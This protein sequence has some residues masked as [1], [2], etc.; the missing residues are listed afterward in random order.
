MSALRR[1]MCALSLPLFLSLSPSALCLVLPAIGLRTRACPVG[2]GRDTRRRPK[3]RS[4]A[5]KNSHHHHQQ[6]HPLNHR[7]YSICT[8]TAIPTATQCNQFYPPTANRKPRPE[9]TCASAA[10]GACVRARAGCCWWWLVGT[11]PGQSEAPPFDKDHDT[12]LARLLGLNL[13]RAAVLPGPIP[14]SPLRQS[15]TNTTPRTNDRDIHPSTRIPHTED[16][17]TSCLIGDGFSLRGWLA[18]LLLF[19]ADISHHTISLD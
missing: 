18:V 5:R 1:G 2:D 17:S 4:L 16:C 9:I 15:P 10:R 8:P 12:S 3:P 7:L 6:H 13:R 14:G 11:K 19:G